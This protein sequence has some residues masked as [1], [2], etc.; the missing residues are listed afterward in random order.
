MKY[1]LNQWA[2]ISSLLT[3]KSAKQ[4]KA[5][6]Y[7]WLDP[8]IR[9]TEWTREEDEKLL[10][11]AK[12]MPTQWRTIA[13]IV[14]RTPAQ[15]LERY[16][17]LLDMAAG[18][19]SYDPTDDPR[20]LR[21]GEIDPNPESKPARPDP[22][23]MDEDEKEML[24]EARARLANTKGKK[25]KRKARERQLEEARRLATL[26][27]KRELKVRVCDGSVACCWVVGRQDLV[28]CVGWENVFRK[29]GCNRQ[30]ESS[31]Q[32]EMRVPLV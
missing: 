9:K 4:C 29:M 6:W 18:K 21:P 1:G 30:N 31:S 23:D 15:C 2:R 32:A 17:K 14:G 11:L 16:E 28:I 12:L 20:R 10:H 5:R 25:A 24:S 8:A 26:Q 27:K 13:P 3:R 7:E 19:E 22:I